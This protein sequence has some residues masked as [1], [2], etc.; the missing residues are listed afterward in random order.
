MLSIIPSSSHK[1]PWERFFPLNGVSVHVQ[2]L[3]RTFQSRQRA[4]CR[5]LSNSNPRDCTTPKRRQPQPA[6]PFSLPL[7][8]CFFL[9]DTL[10]SSEAVLSHVLQHLTF[11]QSQ[12]RFAPPRNCGGL[13]APKTPSSLLSW[14]AFR[15]CCLPGEP[16]EE[17][18]SQS[19]LPQAWAELGRGGTW[20][21]VPCC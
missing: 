6:K 7:S 9:L 5:A 20:A 14:V 10:T 8:Y 17:G 12:S 21:L 13:A 4:R 2:C 19:L 18:G 11:Y 1:D 15:L 3:G 16:K